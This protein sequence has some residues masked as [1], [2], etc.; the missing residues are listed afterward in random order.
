M[1]GVCVQPARRLLSLLSV[2]S[3]RLSDTVYLGK[4]VWGG[5]GRVATNQPPAAAAATNRRREM[6]VV[7][8]KISTPGQ[9][10]R[11]DGHATADT[12]GTGHSGHTDS[13]HAHLRR[14]AQTETPAMPGLVYARHSLPPSKHPPPVSQQASMRLSQQASKGYGRQLACGLVCAFEHDPDP[15]THTHATATSH[16]NDRLCP[17]AAGSTYTRALVTRP[18]HTAHT[19]HSRRSRSTET[20]RR[21]ERNARETGCR[22]QRPTHR[23]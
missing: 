4:C 11:E 17:L 8:C 5:F 3:R 23:T 22:V 21:R 1:T 2:F 7:T 18:I 13:R 12:P 20:T 19:A 9:D 10:T 14:P 16:P 15:H 6:V